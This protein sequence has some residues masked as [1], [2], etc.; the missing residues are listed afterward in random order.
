MLSSSVLAS[1]G[2]SVVSTSST[3]TVVVSSSSSFSVD[4]PSVLWVGSSV[5]SVLSKK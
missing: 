1:V 3:A 5:S 2:A 4:S